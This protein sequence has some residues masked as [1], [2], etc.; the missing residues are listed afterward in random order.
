MTTRT[1]AIKTNEERTA[2]KPTDPFKK[3]A[4]E[5][6]QALDGVNVVSP[7]D[8]EKGILLLMKARREWEHATAEK[9]KII[10]PAKVII[11]TQGGLWKP[12]EDLFEKIDTILTDKLKAWHKAKEDDLTAAYKELEQKGKKMTAVAL[13]SKEQELA[14]KLP[15]KTVYNDLGSATMKDLDG[16]EIVDASKIPDEF[17]TLDATKIRAAVVT[18]GLEVPGV[19]KTTKKSLA[20]SL[21][22]TA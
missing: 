22:P 14:A 21:I 13:A 2:I 10:T 5:F 9:E 16:I 7:A 3:Q 18:Q 12:I 1:K 6:L 4:E 20:I 8:Y 11:K 19:K 17:W 15:P